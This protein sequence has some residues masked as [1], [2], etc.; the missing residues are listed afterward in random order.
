MPATTNKQ[1]ALTQAHA[2]L[3]KKYHPPEPAAADRT[4]LEE[5]V[6]AI[7]REG[8]TRAEADASYDRLK[9]QFLDWNEVRVSTV[10]EVA[11]ALKPLPQAGAKARRVIALVQAVFEERYS[12]DLS[13]LSKKGLK[14][15][16]R[17]LRYYKE[18]MTDFTVAWV[19]QR[20]LGGHAVPLDEP[21]LRVLLRLRVIDET[22]LDSMET[23]RGSIEHVV[24]KSR[25][26]EFGEVL[27]LHARSLCTA[28]DP[29]CPACPLKAEC[30]TGQE[31]LSKKPA[32]AAATEA[33]V[34]KS[35]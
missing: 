4:V 18:C 33:K 25:G 30:P 19:V 22:E 5:V 13:D 3:K 28:D 9:R 24:P 35:R 27:S 2:L 1:Q 23:L 7:A 17:K 14:D 20:V 26:I 21:A 32:A 12:F 34:K 8:A 11:D 29:N 16:A 31:R 15:A 10:Q 6:Y